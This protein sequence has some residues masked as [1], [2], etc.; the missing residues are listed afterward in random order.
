M[1]KVA[2]LM[3][4]VMVLVAGFGCYGTRSVTRS[5]DDWGNEMQTTN[6]WLAQ[7]VGW[8]VIPIAQFF[9]M[10]YDGVIDTYYFWSENAWSNRGTPYVHKVIAKPAK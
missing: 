10:I 2:L 8:F 6:A 5:L 7:P 3:V 9:T 4:I 1:K